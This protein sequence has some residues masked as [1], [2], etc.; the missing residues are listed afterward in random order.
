MEKKTN[1]IGLDISVVIGAPRSGTTLLS[2]L[3]TGNDKSVPNLPECTF[4][5]QIIKHYHDIVNYSD[6]ERFSIYARDEKT[7][8]TQYKKH[9]DGMLNVVVEQF[10]S[11]NYQYLTLKDP[12]LSL[13]VE[14]IPDFFEQ[15][16][17]I[18]IVR[19]PR[20]I[21]SS[22]IRVYQKKN[23]SIDSL[24]FYSDEE[25]L[26]LAG[27]I[28]NYFYL[29]H[30]SEVYKKGLIHVV[31]YEAILDNNLEVFSEL[32][33]FLEYKLTNRAFERNAFEFDKNDPTFS[34]NYGKDI[35]RP[36]S[37]F[38]DFLSPIQVKVIEDMFSGFNLTYK[39][40]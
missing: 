14:L 12:E 6:K 4:I 5:T 23:N 3:I 29:I 32:E 27:D 28:Y 22:L 13:Y 8:F 7:L 21:I 20:A 35:V 39:W 17:I 38:R 25:L 9:V 34:E 24:E 37:N 1:N 10:K 30:E 15:S 18:Y 11:S 16:K 36:V 19:D 2:G 40:W 33:S 26:K 31:S